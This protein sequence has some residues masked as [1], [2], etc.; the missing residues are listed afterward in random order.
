M[1][2]SLRPDVALGVRLSARIARDQFTADPR[3]VIDE[4]LEMAAGHPEVLA[5][6]AGIWAGAHENSEHHRPIASALAGIPGARQWMALG[7]K[8]AGMGHRTIDPR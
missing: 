4:L 7:R 1:S 5:R 2:E 3:P 6:E 8:R